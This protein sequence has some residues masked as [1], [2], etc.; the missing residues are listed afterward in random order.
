MTKSPFIGKGEWST[1]C[2]G[3]IHSDVYGLMNVQAIGG[4]SYFI[5]FIDDHS[6]Y[7]HVYLMK[8]KSEALERF[9]EFRS[10]VE[11]QSGKGIKILW[12]NRGR[13]YLSHELLV[14]LKKNRI[15]SQWTPP[16]IPQHNG[17]SERRNCMLLDMVWS[18][19]SLVDLSKIFWGYT[20]NTT[21]YTLN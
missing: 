16:G 21:I 2:L 19:M 12:S 3:L 18:M 8:H 10:D 17:V 20:L 11:K 13:E 1:E 4:F 14:Y 15:L 6:R 5:M 7:G 9:K